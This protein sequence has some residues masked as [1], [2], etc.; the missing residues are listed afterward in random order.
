LELP[1][2]ADAASA[3]K[4]GVAYQ[5]NRTRKLKLDDA[6]QITESGF[7]IR[8]LP[9]NGFVSNFRTSLLYCTDSVFQ[10]QARLSTSAT[11]RGFHSDNQ[12]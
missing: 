12:E 1:P 8:A 7:Q 5:I 11:V 9:K 6:S 2:V 10:I 4:V 3:V